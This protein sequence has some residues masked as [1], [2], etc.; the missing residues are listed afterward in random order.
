[1]S[2]PALVSAGHRVISL[3]RRSH[4]RSADPAEGHTMRRHGRDIANF[5]DDLDLHP[6]VLVG[7]SMGA[8]AIWSYVEQSGT[9]RVRG[10][11]SVDQTPKMV[12]TED[13]PYGFYG[14]TEAG[15]DTMFAAGIPNTGRAPKRDAATKRR[16]IRA[17]GG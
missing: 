16:M 14:Y 7:G 4:G 2:V 8:S 15:R 17:F 12:N 10:V 3:D 1:I 9:G 6:A 13:W 11:V 5:L